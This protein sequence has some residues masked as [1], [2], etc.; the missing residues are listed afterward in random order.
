MIV[1]R[2]SCGWPKP[3]IAVTNT[4]GSLPDGG[5]SVR[6]ICPVCEVPYT[7]GECAPPDVR[8]AD[9]E[10]V[11]R[12]DEAATLQQQVP[13]PAQLDV[14]VRDLKLLDGGG[15][16]SVCSYSPGDADANVP[17]TEV[18]LLLQLGKGR[19][20]VLR[21]KSSA[22]VDELVA[23]LLEYRGQVWPGQARAS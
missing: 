14:N 13:P 10:S 4:D 2:C 15:V 3:L 17:C 18:H 5:L 19:S 23:L 21:L 16:Y 1:K 9:R 6:A 8:R 11:V 12:H 20:A 7:A 22:R